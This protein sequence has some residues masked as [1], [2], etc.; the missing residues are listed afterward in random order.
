M[1]TSLTNIFKTEQKNNHN[2][3]PYTRYPSFTAAPF[4]F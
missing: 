2:Y 3:K 4:Y 1:A